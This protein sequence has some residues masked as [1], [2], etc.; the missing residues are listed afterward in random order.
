MLALV[1]PKGWG[2]IEEELEKEKHCWL[3]AEQHSLREDLGLRP[4]RPWKEEE[5]Y[6][7]TRPKYFSEN[8]WG[9]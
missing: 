9:I 6:L 2:K 5:V 4:F 7:I 8:I 1:S 3:R